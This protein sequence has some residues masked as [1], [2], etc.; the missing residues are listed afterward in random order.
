[1]RAING[2]RRAVV[3]A[4]AF[5]VIAVTALIAF[6]AYSSNRATSRR[7]LE[8]EIRAT[9]G[10]G[11]RLFW[12]ADQQWGAEQ[13]FTQVVRP[14][15]ESFQHLRF[16]LP[17]EGMPW[18]RLDIV[19]ADGDVWLKDASLLDSRERVIGVVNADTFRPVN[20]T[21]ILSRD[22]EVMRVRAT[23][24]TT[25]A[26]L[27]TTLACLDRVTPLGRLS[28]VTPT[29]LALATAATAA[30]LLACVLI[31]ARA[32]YGWGNPVVAS[33]GSS[34][35]T[36]MATLWLASLFLV[37]FSAKLI[38]M[39]QTPVTAPFWDQWNAE[40]ENLLLPY[41]E[42]SLSWSQMFA[43]HNEH[44]VFFTRLL[45]LDLIAANGQWDPRL[46]QVVNAAVHASTA[47]LLA[48]IL[49]LAHKRRRLD[50][51]VLVCGVVFAVPFGWEN[52]LVGF[53]SSFYF[54]VLFSILAL[55]LTTYPAGTTPWATGWICATCAL[56]T[57]AGGLVT[58]GVIVGM[59]LLSV[60]DE[61]HR[62]RS[63]LATLFV[64]TGV[65][66]LGVVTA[67]PPIAAHAPLRA[68]SAKEFLAAFTANLAWPW[69]E[70]AVA[71]I[72][73]WLPVVVLVIALVRRRLRTTPLDRLV[74]GLAAWVV[75]NAVAVAFGRGSGG[76]ATAS[77]YMDLLS[78]GIVA[79]AM[80]LPSLLDDV[81]GRQVARRIV[82][83]TLVVWL[84]FVIGGI[85]HLE[86]RTSS[87][88]E[89][90]RQFW[91]A[92]ATNVRKFV[93]DH[94]RAAFT[95]KRPLIDL[96][97]PD[98]GTLV[99]LL[100]N[101]AF[102]RVLP[103][104]LREPLKVEPRAM[105]GD[106]F[107]TSSPMA[108][109]M[110]QDPLVSA[111]WSLSTKGRSAEGEFDSRPLAC[112][113]TGRLKFLVAGYLGW[114]NQYLALRTVNERRDTPV[115][116]VRLAREDW[117][118]AVVPCPSGPFEIVAIDKSP[119]S[120]FSFREPVEVGLGSLVSEWLIDRSQTLFIIGLALAGLAARWSATPI[121][122]VVPVL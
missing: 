111:W 121:S 22:G 19:N 84:V 114:E 64:A 86:R 112:Q 62:W 34:T 70:T 101:P 15:S 27:M 52:T 105:S 13:S 102:R 99:R 119:D 116:P 61:P 80:A 37:V 5:C 51:V 9:S 41:A 89:N 31:V 122:P 28:R 118:D 117:A 75:L 73:V 24:G 20:D 10:S 115:H 45:A 96:P 83:G 43:L 26:S 97:Y 93:L 23:P 69:R 57:I 17:P 32:A 1:M 14:S 33:T 18:I 42:C 47:V 79:N 94:D 65:L 11:V 71:G 35:T 63:E 21:A 8:I 103:A 48:A 44:R 113:S 6:L 12:S 92:Q 77:R 4:S 49:W 38:L 36:R 59:T 29:T 110:P 40:G 54:F 87:D 90:Y 68:H 53:Q 3:A 120:W 76:G 72:A 67:S 106:A 85:I 56:F 16:P 100:E 104:T 58:I 109:G 50:L 30:L 108:R 46:E 2:R 82:H 78:I 98:P 7:S 66:A 107:V 25:D 81:K 55:W 39:H 74:V 95:A 88:L 91:A 60:I